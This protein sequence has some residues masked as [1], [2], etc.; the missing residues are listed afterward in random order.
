MVTLANCNLANFRSHQSSIVIIT[1]IQTDEISTLLYLPVYS[2][3]GEDF[4]P[5]RNTGLS[6]IL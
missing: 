4:I 1:S 5:L 2:F 6:Y 3:V